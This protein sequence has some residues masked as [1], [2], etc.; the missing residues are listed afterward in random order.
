MAKTLLTKVLSR[1]DPNFVDLRSPSGAALGVLAYD[2]TGDIYTG[3]EARMLAQ[4]GKPQFKVGHVASSDYNQVIGHPLVRAAAAATFLDNQPMCSQCAYKPYCGLDSVYN[5]ETQ[6]T[7]W[8]RMPDNRR[9]EILMGMFDVL[10]EKI[11]NPENL[12][13]FQSWF[14]APAPAP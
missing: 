9:C 10:F 5:Y 13:V 2:T 6:D 11:Q 4:E 8:G 7:L 14:N 3:D 1:L 12:K